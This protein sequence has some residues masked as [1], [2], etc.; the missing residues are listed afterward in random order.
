M[1]TT[2]F[3]GI[4]EKCPTADETP[5]GANHLIGSHLKTRPG[6]AKIDSVATGNP[7]M[8]IG[9]LKSD[10]CFQ[11]FELIIEDDLVTHRF[12]FSD[13]FNDGIIDT[14]KWVQIGLPS[15]EADGV[16]IHSDL[17]GLGLA[18]LESVNTFSGDMEMDINWVKIP[19]PFSPFWEIYSGLQIIMIDGHVF[20]M[21]RYDDTNASPDVFRYVARYGSHYAALSALGRFDKDVSNAKFRIKRIGSTIE[22]F[23]SEDGGATW[24]LLG[25]ATGASTAD[26]KVRIQ[27]RAATFGAIHWDNFVLR[28]YSS[29][30]LLKSN[31][32]G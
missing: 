11:G 15:K 27:T 26:F 14:A 32:L 2:N 8:E 19:P 10:D 3:F 20:E 17:G 30:A 31:P 22:G 18:I 29:W 9:H 25:A 21:G 1:P 6:I 4:R 23:Y 7:I 16:L 12:L 13:D 28:G 24:I 5:D